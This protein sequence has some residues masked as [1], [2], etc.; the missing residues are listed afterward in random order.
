MEGYACNGWDKNGDW[1]SGLDQPLFLEI[2]VRLPVVDVS[3][4]VLKLLHRLLLKDLIFTFS[5]QLLRH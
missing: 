2:L 5:L 1:K 3:F 4:L